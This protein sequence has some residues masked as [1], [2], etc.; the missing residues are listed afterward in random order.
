MGVRGAQIGELEALYRGSLPR[1][2]RTASAIVGD[3]AGGRDA[4][5]DAFVRAVRQRGTFRQE[6]ALEAWV[7]RIV[8]HSALDLRANRHREPVDG[9]LVDEFAGNGV[10]EADVEVRAWVAALPERQRLAVFLRYFAGLDYRGIAAA[11]EV[12]VGTVSA[13][14]S[15]AHAALRRSFQEVQR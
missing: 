9:P 4:V 10:P 1:F 2:V 6:V 13:T 7:W 3:E 15:A 12:E 14:L 11:L 8:V 5:Q